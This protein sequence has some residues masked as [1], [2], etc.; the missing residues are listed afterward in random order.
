MPTP[1]PA[2]HFFDCCFASAPQQRPLSVCARRSLS[3]RRD[4]AGGV[5][6]LVGHLGS[7]SGTR[8]GCW[9]NS[10]ADLR[11]CAA[12]PLCPA[13]RQAD[14]T[15]VFALPK[16]EGKKSKFGSIDELVAYHVE[17]KGGLP[18]KLVLG[19]HS[20]SGEGDVSDLGN[21]VSEV[22]YDELPDVSSGG[23]G[24]GTCPATCHH[25]V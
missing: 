13:P 11:A 5:C 19:S 12:L 20:Q 15:S 24:G 10:T 16:V 17:K 14:G 22:T 23:G 18:C 21:T 3:K 9:A 4:G 1:H 2:P 8:P 6:S 7:D 25:P